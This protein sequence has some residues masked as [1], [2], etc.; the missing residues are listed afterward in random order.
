MA[1]RFARTRT[2]CAR[3]AG[4]IGAV[5]SMTA[6]VFAGL[7][8]VAPAGTAGSPNIIRIVVD[9]QSWI[10]TSVLM[11]PAN[12]RSGSDYFQTPNLQSL[13]DEGMR[14]SSAYVSPICRPTQMALH[15]G[16][17]WTQLQ[18]THNG[19]QTNAS[20]YGRA[21]TRPWVRDGNRADL[22]AA[23][24]VK[25]AD[26]AYRTAHFGKY[27]TASILGNWGF[28]ALSN[29][30]T[31]PAA[32]DPKL[33][34]SFAEQA[35]Q[36]IQDS[37]DADRPFYVEFHHNA[38]KGPAVALP[39]TIQKYN[40]LP[41]GQMHRDHEFAA[42]TEN[43]DTSVGMVLDRI[44]DL[45]VDDETYV[46][47][48]SDNGGRWLSSPWG[49]NPRNVPLFGGKDMLWEGGIRV[50]MIVKGPGI[51]PGTVSDVPVIAMD[52]FTTIADMAGSPYDMHDGIEGTSLMPILENGGD[53]PDGMTSLSRQHAEDG[54]IYFHYT[55]QPHL[56]SAVIDGAYKLV[57]TYGVPGPDARNLHLFHIGANPHESE[58]LDDSSNLADEMPDLTA[59]LH[60]KLND[61]LEAVDAS[62]PYDVRDPAVLTW[63]ADHLGPQD[64]VELDILRASL[65]TTRQ[66]SDLNADG[67]VDER[68]L[69]MAL[70]RHPKTWR[71]VENVDYKDRELWTFP[72]D[73]AS[74]PAHVAIDPHQP[75]LPRHALRFDGDDRAERIFFNVAD[76]AGVVG[77]DGDHSATVEAWVRLDRLD[78][79]HL[80]FESGSSDAGISMA[81][82][83]EDGDGD[84]TDLRFRVRDAEG[85]AL[86]VSASLDLFADPTQDFVHVVGVFSDDDSDRF[87]ELY[88]N[89][90]LRGR[91]QGATGFAEQIKWDRFDRAGLGG[92]GGDGVGGSAGDSIPL[93]A[94]AAL[95]GDV[96]LL[97]FYN[98]AIDPGTIAQHYGE[99]LD[100]IGVGVVGM[101][102]MLTVPADRP[103]DLSEGAF[104]RDDSV[105]VMLE[106]RD[107]LSRQSQVDIVPEPDARYDDATNLAVT[108]GAL[109]ADTPVSVYLVQFDPV[110]DPA[111][112]ASYIGRVTFEEPII[113]V[114]VDEALLA[115]TDGQLGSF[116]RYAT[117][118]RGR[119]L[120]GDSFI[121]LSRDL[122]MLTVSGGVVGAEVMQIRVLTH[123]VPEPSALVTFVAVTALLARRGRSRHAR[124]SS[125]GSPGT[126]RCPSVALSG[127]Q[128]RSH[129][130]FRLTSTTSGS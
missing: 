116:G 18:I 33:M 9:D 59:Q 39:E 26:P 55:N 115:Q 102:G 41:R 109:P 125:H 93:P 119:A 80:V 82:G 57:K 74:R 98:H 85:Q 67:I 7:A 111:S 36:F 17:S 61:W 108:A 99:Q 105:F 66:R 62:L 84:A 101:S 20:G 124:S 21:L 70:A 68:D 100:P 19:N 51:A 128:P 130:S 14:F 78:R 40:D 89:G 28:D 24:V 22:S 107:R 79:P 6:I 11:D 45:G 38:V 16:K 97:R 87:A 77:L 43:L 96:A 46:I 110:G 8:V 118:L 63:N 123:Y 91:A 103:N 122:R 114:I 72:E 106:R 34:F 117:A 112:P 27:G 32:E 113:G 90:A 94:D 12:P 126:R 54:A 1:A 127:P 71:A 42:M 15:T 10:G 37:V 35:N 31:L 88:V 13:A 120:S 5:P 44:R 104:E 56:S 53:L 83:D 29:T 86:T 75:G 25:E 95:D 50:P 52:V 2:L 129:A 60:Q 69:E 121:R 23:Q 58:R 4:L 65:G 73:D 49:G 64:D 76:P 30:R 81:V 47:Y 92:R 48:T 3:I